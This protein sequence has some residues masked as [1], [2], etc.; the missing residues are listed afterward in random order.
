VLIP[1][2]V[3]ANERRIGDTFGNLNVLWRMNE[4]IFLIEE[5]VE[6]GFTARALGESIFTEADTLDA[7]R[8][9]VRDAVNCHFDEGNAPK[10]IRLH[11]VRDEVLAG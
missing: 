7:L 10:V 4:I 11:F 8:Q 5:A 2:S 3:L 1:E 6:G 9:Q